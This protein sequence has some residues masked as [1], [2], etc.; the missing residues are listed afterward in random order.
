LMEM[1]ILNK[2]H[3][4]CEVFGFSPI[5]VF[6]VGLLISVIGAAGCGQS[7][8]VALTAE[9]TSTAKVVA[10]TTSAA[11][12]ERFRVTPHASNSELGGQ[13]IE[14]SG[15]VILVGTS[16]DLGD[17]I[18]LS[19]GS[20]G[21]KPVV[22]QMAEPRPW[23]RVTPG[24]PVTVKGQVWRMQP[25]S[26]PLLRQAHLVHVDSLMAES[27]RFAAED[28]CASFADSRSEAH[29]VL[30]ERWIRVTGAVASID[31]I[32]GWLYLTGGTGRLVRCALA[33]KE[34]ELSW[35]DDLKAAEIIEVVGQ[36]ADGDRRQVILQG[37]LPPRRNVV[38][39]VSAQGSSPDGLQPGIEG[40]GTQTPSEE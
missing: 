31:R 15:G 14:V 4:A 3:G 6:G 11:L 19:G 40:P 5:A 38:G 21:S 35:D 9:E 18:L 32:N 36:V 1:G 34:G 10:Q 17:V 28:V 12:Q 7:P 24:M 25:G 26:A 30:G 13:V 27:M 22:C 8:L 23:D 37:C 16:P 39:H 2:N 33:G 29:E 20:K